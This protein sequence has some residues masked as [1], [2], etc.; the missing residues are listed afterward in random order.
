MADRESAQR[1]DEWFAQLRE[2]FLAIARRRVPEDA[3]EDLVQEALRIVHEKRDLLARA[4]A[5]DGTPALAW[6]FQV[7]RNVIGNFYQRE[8][9]RSDA[10]PVALR[11]ALA[12]DAPPVTPLESLEEREAERRITEAVDELADGAGDCAR[13]VRALLDGLE[14]AAIAKREGVSAPVLSRRLYRC[15]AKLRVILERRGVLT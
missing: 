1:G 14:P 9:T 4:D 11:A 13:Y 3:A 15:R 10:D 2:R 8:R 5:V 12:E 6:C 7:L